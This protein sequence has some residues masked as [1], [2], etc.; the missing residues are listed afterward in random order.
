MAR[1]NSLTI[2]MVGDKELIRAMQKEV[3]KARAALGKAVIAGADIVKAEIEQE[4]ERRR[5]TGAA[6]S[7]FA[8][9]PGSINDK[10]GFNA[11]VTLAQRGKDREYPFFMEFGVKDRKR[12]GTLPKFGLMRK[13]YDRTSAKATEITEKII[14]QEMGL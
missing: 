13:A 14:R 5:D 3:K 9:K 1:K 10:D 7:N 11:V 6:A 2:N 12:G 4:F 8:T